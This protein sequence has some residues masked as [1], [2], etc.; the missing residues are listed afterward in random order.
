MGIC[1][2]QS[3]TTVKPLLPPCPRILTD[4]LMREQAAAQHTVA[5]YR[6]KLS[7]AHDAVRKMERAYADQAEVGAGHGWSCKG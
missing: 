4:K 1:A 7:Q 2:R 6:Q 3:R 5:L